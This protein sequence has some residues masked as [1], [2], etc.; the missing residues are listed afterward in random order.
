M[1]AENSAP[2]VPL[3][4]TRRAGALVFVSGQLPRK[5]EGGMCEGDIGEQTAQAIANLKAALHSEG[6]TLADV[7]KTTVWLTSSEHARGM[8]AVYA[9]MFPQPYPTRSTVVS[10]LVAKADIEIEAVAF[11]PGAD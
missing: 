9:D 11:G 6:L 2:N 5:P 10:G 4:K 3:S 8:N 1:S 7:V